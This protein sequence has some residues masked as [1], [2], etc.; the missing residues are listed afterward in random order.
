MMLDQDY[1]TLGLVLVEND[2]TCFPMIVVPIIW[3]KEWHEGYR[4]LFQAV[5]FNQCHHGVIGRLSSLNE[6]S[7]VV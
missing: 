5:Q 7:P 1:K 2:A 4:H 6:V 3:Y